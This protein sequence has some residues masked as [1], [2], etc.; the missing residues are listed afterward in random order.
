VSKKQRRRKELQPATE[1]NNGAEA[2]N[3]TQKQIKKKGEERRESQTILQLSTTSE[4][5]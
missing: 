2:E 5:F 1:E 3:P 4:G